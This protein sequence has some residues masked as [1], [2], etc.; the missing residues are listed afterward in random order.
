MK[1][2]ILGERRR[3]NNLYIRDLLF[4]CLLFGGK[5]GDDFGREF[6]DTQL[7]HFQ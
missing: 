3:T 7:N 1:N 2:T 5:R 6:L 4:Y